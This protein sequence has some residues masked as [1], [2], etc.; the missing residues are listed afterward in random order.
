MHHRQEA[1][2]NNTDVIPLKLRLENPKKSLVAWIEV[3]PSSCTWSG[4]LPSVKELN[5]T[6]HLDQ[7]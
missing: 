4:A 3:H 7:E 2:Q 6:K 5:K 1:A